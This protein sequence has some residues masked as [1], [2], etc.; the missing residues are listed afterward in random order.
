MYK[1]KTAFVIQTIVI[2][3]LYV[4]LTLIANMFG[5][6]NGII[7]VRIS[8]ALTVLP[9]FTPAA[10][11]GLF[12]G[13]LTANY[14]MGN[15]MYDVLIGSS[16]TLVA[17]VI[18]YLVRKYKFA[19]PIP[20]IVVTAFTIPFIYNVLLRLDDHSFWASVALVGTGEIISCG[21]LGVAV[22]LGL[23][24]YKDKLFPQGKSKE[25]KDN[26]EEIKKQEINNV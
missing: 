13:C 9:Y 17:A 18:S 15:P 14:I 12:I 26:K 20:P 22:M 10:I 3:A 1:G 11:P 8:E 2:A 16:A 6:A 23:E 5:M 4:I 19:V 21:V 25:P 24:D 7:Q